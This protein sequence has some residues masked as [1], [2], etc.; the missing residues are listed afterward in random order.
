MIEIKFAENL[1]QLRQ[2]KGMTQQELAQK[3]GVDKRTVSAWE[4]KVCEPSFLILAKLCDIFDE[5]FDNLLT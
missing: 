1:K 2:S 3:L 5:N 4:T